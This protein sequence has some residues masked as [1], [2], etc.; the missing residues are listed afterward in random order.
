LLSVDGTDYRIAMN[1][2]KDF[3]SYKFK[4]CGYRY[5]IG[6]NIITGDIC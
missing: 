5:E 1:Y 2:R 6:L 4:A 3:Y